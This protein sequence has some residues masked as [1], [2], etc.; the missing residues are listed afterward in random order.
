M[1]FG[2]GWSGSASCGFGS[3]YF[4]IWHYAVIIGVVIIIFAIVSL[5]KSKSSTTSGAV[6]KLKNLYIS[7]EI[8]EEEY[9]KRKNVIERK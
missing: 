4:S 2:N 5:K 3:G 7:G 9:L 8:S 6:E 1:M